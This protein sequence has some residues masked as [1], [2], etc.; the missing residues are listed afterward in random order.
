VKEIGEDAFCGCSS[1]TSI[2]IPSSVTEIGDYAFYG[3]SKLSSITIPP[4]LT[5]IGEGAFD[6]C[7]CF[8]DLV[9]NNYSYSDGRDYDVENYDNDYYDFDEP[10]YGRYAGSYAQD[11]E[12]WSDDDIDNVFDGDPDAYWNID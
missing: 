4:L 2:T 1:L 11:V 3:C 8:H 10:S 7:P 9:N 5:E 12:G 6:G